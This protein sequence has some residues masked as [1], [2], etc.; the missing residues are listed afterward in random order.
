MRVGIRQSVGNVE[1][2]V[3]MLRN[4]NWHTEGSLTKDKGIRKLTSGRIASSSNRIYS[5]FE[6]RFTGGTQEIL[7]FRDTGAAGVVHKLTASLGGWTFG[8]AL[9]TSLAR[10]KPCVLMF[11]NQVVVLDGVAG[12][13]YS[14]GGATLTSTI[15]DSPFSTCTFGVVYANRLILFGDPGTPY[16]FYPSGVRDATDFDAAQAY[17]VMGV[18]GERI[19]GAGTCGP[20]LLVGGEE[21]TRAFYLGTAS[22][23]DWDWDSLSEQTGPINWQSF[24]EVTQIG[25]A[26]V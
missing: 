18:H 20:F 6:A 7:A 17:Y 14:A 22:A 8:T 13:T 25:R 2:H 10:T 12:Y 16:H 9:G 5:C 23:M 26:H 4:L 3:S 1:P 19:L 15:S 21:F 24:V 11:A